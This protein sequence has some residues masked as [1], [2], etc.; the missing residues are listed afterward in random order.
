MHIAHSKWLESLKLPVVA[1]D[2]FL[3]MPRSTTLFAHIVL[4]F[5][6]QHLVTQLIDSYVTTSATDT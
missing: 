6:L 4:H 1:F 5:R 3:R 2:P